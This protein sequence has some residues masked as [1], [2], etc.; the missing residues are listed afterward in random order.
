MMELTGG[1]VGVGV[2]ITCKVAVGLGAGGVLVARD[3]GVFVGVM[4]IE[5]VADGAGKNVA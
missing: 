3:G 1:L 4:E 5:P 2:P